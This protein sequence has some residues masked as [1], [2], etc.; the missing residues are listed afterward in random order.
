MYDEHGRN[1]L[2]ENL[3]DQ[4]A[5]IINMTSGLSTSASQY[6]NIFDQ[7]QSVYADGKEQIK[8]KLNQRLK[9]HEEF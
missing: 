8:T 6:L 1:H 5:S 4:H 7:F 2:L 3:S 9:T